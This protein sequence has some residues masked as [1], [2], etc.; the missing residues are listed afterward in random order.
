MNDFRVIH[1][2]DKHHHIVYSQ[3]KFP[4]PLSPRDCTYSKFISKDQTNGVYVACWR[5]VCAILRI[6]CF[7]FNT[8]V[9]ML[10]ASCGS[11]FFSCVTALVW[12]YCTLVSRPCS[13]PDF[14]KRKGITRMWGYGASKFVRLEKGRC[15]CWVFVA[16]NPKGNIPGW[17]INTAMPRIAIKSVVDLRDKALEV[18][19]KKRIQKQLSLEGKRLLAGV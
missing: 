6:D 18:Q 13:H 17:L 4:F 12:I 9:T 10:G 8:S 3:A 7:V 16:G 2:F 11:L 14:P 1:N 5:F 15:R 19:K